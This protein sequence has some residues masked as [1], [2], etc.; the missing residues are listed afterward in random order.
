MK[1]EIKSNRIFIRLNDEELDQI[2]KSSRDA[3]LSMSAFARKRLMGEKVSARF[4]E[5]YL[6]LRRDISGLCNNV[7]QIARAV[8]GKCLAPLPAAEEA[9]VLVQNIY[10][11]MRGGIDHSRK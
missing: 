3:G 6:S 9:R 2:R 8:N 10:N 11:L 7:N 1:K 5:D 4:S